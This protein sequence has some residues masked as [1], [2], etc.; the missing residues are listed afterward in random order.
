MN[1]KSKKRKRNPESYKRNVLKKAKVKGL[2]HITYSGKLVPA[3]ITGDD[4]RR[5]FS[6]VINRNM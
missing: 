6:L 1:V 4:C 2:E 3:R 5:V